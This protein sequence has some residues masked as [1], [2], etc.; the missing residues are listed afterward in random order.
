MVL[1]PPMPLAVPLTA[2]KPGR[3]V[4][5][6]ESSNAGSAHTV[7]SAFPAAGSVLSSR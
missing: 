3:P 1:P 5:H 4:F 7:R 6:A 2:P